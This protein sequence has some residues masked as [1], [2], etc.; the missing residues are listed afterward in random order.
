MSEASASQ[1]GRLR[2]LPM[3]AGLFVA[4]TLFLGAVIVVHF[5]VDYR[6]ERTLRDTRETLNVELA[7]RALAADIAAVTTD[8]MFLGRLVES[9][10]FDPV[11]AEGRQRYLAEVFLTFARE[12]GLY[13]QIR[14]LD[15]EGQ[16]VV[17]VNLAG[18][19]PVLVGGSQLRDKSGR[20]YVAKALRLDKGQVYLSP[21]DLNIEDGA[22]EQPIKPVLRFATPV[23][24][25]EGRR[26][27]L[28]VLNYLGDLLLDRF[29]QAAAN[30]AD[31]VQ[32]L[33]GDGYWLSSPR[34]NEAWGFMFGRED[35]FQRRFAVA[36]GKIKEEQSGQFISVGGL[37]TFS[38]VRPAA[39]AARALPPGGVPA[40]Q[41]ETWKVVSNVSLDAASLGLGAFVARHAA[42]YLGILGLMAVLAYLLASATVHRRAAEAQR[43]YERRFRQTLED[44]GLVALMVDPRGRLTFCNQFLLDLTG[45]GREE[46]IGSEWIERFVPDE[47]K[48]AV[49]TVLQR[50]ARDGDFPPQFEG[51]VCTRQG[52]RR[53]I[54][55]NNTPA[56]DPEGRLIGLTAI[57][58]DI[59]ERRRAEAQV[60]KLSQ[61]VEQS[62]AIVQI[63]D[64]VGDIEYV[65]P[66]FTEVTGYSFEEV[67]GCNPRLLKSGEMAPSEYRKMWEALAGGGE[68]RG[69]F[70]NRR[71]N[72][73]LYWESAVISALRDADGE[74]THF[75]AV[76]EDITEHKRLQQEVDTRNRE[77]ARSQALAAMGQMATMLAHDLRNPLSS[78][79]MAVQILG[80]QARSG[81]EQEL[82]SIGQEQV[83][84]MEDIITDMLTFSRPGELNTTWLSADKLL[85]G[86]IGTVRRRIAEYEVDVEIDCPPGLPTFPGDASKLRQLLANL[87]VNALQAA[88]A[89]PVGERRVVVS[90][91][92]ELQP[93]GRRLRIEVCD[94]GDGID[95][96]VREHLFEP[97]FTT[98]TK[99]TGLGLAIV[100][101]IAELHAGTVELRKNEPC[102]TCVVLT[103]PQTPAAAEEPPQQDARVAG[104]ESA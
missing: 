77:L 21:L 82:A 13:D 51:E 52:D 104:E 65:N 10:S 19:D 94:N 92:L 1:S 30:I 95:P 5:Y 91:D 103:L 74:I 40:T 64:R 46:V 56:R 81:E 93:E 90:A 80:K 22:V 99:G 59:T 44:I 78:V 24:D 58:E 67:K 14:F 66:K 87:L 9:L 8:L 85:N 38:T 18:G 6:A 33:N 25:S 27:G 69:E 102:G 42:L 86:V 89:R 50:L 97:F 49:R 70:H 53:L 41:G 15:T 73:S 88:V 76:K 96:E 16:E 17:R 23:F 2:T 57:G 34:P 39:H 55:W 4:L 26:Q 45:W 75:L 61:A 71:K 100:R 7:R 84:Y 31:H 68:W 47:Q 43:A 98:R 83:H 72:G 28:V 60:R 29:R 12:K 36:W 62:P 20:Y 32:L 11:V 54:A 101:Q 48:D 35:T 3:F 79:K 63:T 37:F